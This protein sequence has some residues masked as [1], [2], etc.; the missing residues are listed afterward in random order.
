V[1]SQLRNGEGGEA[2]AHKASRPLHF[3]SSLHHLLCRSSCSQIFCVQKIRFA[4][5]LC[6]HTVKFFLLGGV[7][8]RRSCPAS[9]VGHLCGGSEVRGHATPF[10]VR[11]HADPLRGNHLYR[12]AALRVPR[13]RHSSWGQQGGSPARYANISP[14]LVEILTYSMLRTTQNS[15]VSPSSS[16]KVYQY[17]WKDRTMQM[18]GFQYCFVFAKSHVWSSIRIPDMLSYFGVF[19]TPYRSDS[20][21]VGRA[22]LGGGG[23]RDP[24]GG[25]KRCVEKKI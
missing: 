18:N 12:Y 9:W 10:S 25:R 2:I 15:F 14:S 19:L 6:D 24:Q 11:S 17:S 22:S 21:S 5:L 20:Q 7:R 13:S 4:E 3:P 1:A 8:L 16:H 23:A